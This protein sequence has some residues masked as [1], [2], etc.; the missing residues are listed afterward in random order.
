MKLRE[1]LTLL[2]LFLPGWVLHVSGKPLAKIQGLSMVE[3]VY[4]RSA[5]SKNLKRLRGHL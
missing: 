5:M 4:K 1:N 2:E 3:H